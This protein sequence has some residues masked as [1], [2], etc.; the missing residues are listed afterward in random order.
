VTQEDIDLA[1]QQL[2]QPEVVEQEEQV[3]EPV[4]QQQDPEPVQTQIDPMEPEPTAAEPMKDPWSSAQAAPSAWEQPAQ[5]S[6]E[7]AAPAVTETS[8]PAAESY[9]GPPGFNAA[10]R[11]TT[12]PYRTNSRAA[13]RYKADGQA[14]MLPG[15]A[16]G[17][18]S[19]DMK[20]GSL[21]FG[22][23]DADE[24]E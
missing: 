13:L 4:Q 22:N 7:Q 24:T 14:V 23:P 5:Q 16:A 11:A 18:S 20:F 10:V 19:L 21:N 9:T 12:T 3:E 2:D 17:S 8:K 6:K 1:P 15:S